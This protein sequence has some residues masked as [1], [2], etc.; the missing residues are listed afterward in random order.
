MPKSRLLAL[1][2][3]CPLEEVFLAL[4]LLLYWQ[5]ALLVLFWTIKNPELV[6]NACTNGSKLKQLTRILIRNY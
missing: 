3:S 2:R 5:K 4:L 1:G 6:Y